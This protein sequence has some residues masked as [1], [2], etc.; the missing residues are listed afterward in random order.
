[1][2][3]IRWLW[4]WVSSLSVTEI[5]VWTIACFLIA[6]WGK[7]NWDRLTLFWKVHVIAFWIYGFALDVVWN[8][9]VGFMFLE[10]PPIVDH[11]VFG[12]NVRCPELLFSSRVQRI[13][14]T[15]DGWRL[16]LASFWKRNLNIPDPG[17]I[18]DTR[19]FGP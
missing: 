19:R 11:E 5:W 13:Y 9:T 14:S 17:H 16:R 8:Y 3:L 4:T 7:N 10:L 6:M 18:R 2:F 1:M 15:E 12:K